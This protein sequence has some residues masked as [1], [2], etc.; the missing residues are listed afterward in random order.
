[1][2]GYQ[3]MF[4]TKF[5]FKTIN[6]ERS[7]KQFTQ[8]T[9]FISYIVILI[10]KCLKFKGPCSCILSISKLNHIFSREDSKYNLRDF[11]NTS[12][13]SFK[14]HRVNS[15]SKYPPY[16]ESFS[17]HHPPCMRYADVHVSEGRFPEMSKESAV[18]LIYAT[19]PK[20]RSRPLINFITPCP[21]VYDKC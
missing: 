21:A 18:G 2:D 19:P 13:I 10:L 15:S 9:S 5:L 1:M 8:R 4:I 17:E 11:C 12:K 20:A 16:E 14:I 7:S 3:E 6:K